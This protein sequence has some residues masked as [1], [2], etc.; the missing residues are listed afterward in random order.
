[1]STS[2]DAPPSL[3][4]RAD[5]QKQADAPA[6]TTTSSESTTTENDAPA[7]TTTESQTRTTNNNDPP[8][9]TTNDETTTDDATVKNDQTAVITTPV[10]IN[11]THDDSFLQDDHLVESIEQKPEVQPFPDQSSIAEEYTPAPPNTP[12]DSPDIEQQPSDKS[13]ESSNEDMMCDFDD[14]HEN[15]LEQVT[16]TLGRLIIFGVA[17]PFICGSTT[18]NSS[19]LL[20]EVDGDQHV[21][22]FMNRLVC[23]VTEL[24]Q[25]FL[26]SVFNFDIVGAIAYRQAFGHRV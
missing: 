9:E 15:V 25:V 18:F 23:S 5:E 13:D 3:P 11:Q 21:N 24:P 7:E 4:P 17:A 12:D 2:E 10:V 20:R 14:G 19:R 6:E 8:A 22:G 1:M 26:A 16:K